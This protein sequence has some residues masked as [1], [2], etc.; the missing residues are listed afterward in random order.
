[1]TSIF[2]HAITCIAA[3]AS[4]FAVLYFLASSQAATDRHNTSMM[5]VCVD[6]G[7]QWLK[8]YTRTWSCVRPEG[9]P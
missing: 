4:L 1:M 6:A 8:N 5:K 3:T 9:R 2:K 7:G